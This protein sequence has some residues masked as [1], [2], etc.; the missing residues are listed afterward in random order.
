[1]VTLS[2]FISAVEDVNI[3]VGLMLKCK[4][5]DITLVKSSKGP[6]SSYIICSVK[7]FRFLSLSHENGVSHFREQ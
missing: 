2:I 4:K 7:N 6:M 1:M 3:L 5:H